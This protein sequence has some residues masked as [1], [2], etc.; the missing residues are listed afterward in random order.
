[1]SSRDIKPASESVK[2]KTEG[3]G[4]WN[5]NPDFKGGTNL[6]E[7]PQVDWA[8][9]WG[10]NWSAV[11]SFNPTDGSSG[12]HLFNANGAAFQIDSLNNI[13]FSAG[14]PSQGGCGGKLV[15]NVQSKITK[16]GSIATEVTGREDAGVLSK[17]ETEKGTIDNE[18]LPAYSLKVYGDILIECIGG[19]IAVKGDNVTVSAL[20][21]LNLKSEK[22]INIQAN[23]NVNIDGAN[24]DMEAASFKKN[25][26]VGEFTTGGGESSTE[27]FKSGA[28]I[29]NTTPGS[30]EYT[31]SGDYTVG[32]KGLYKLGIDGNYEF[33]VKKDLAYV[34]EGNYSSIIKGKSKQE[35]QGGGKSTQQ[36]TLLMSIGASKSKKNPG[37]GITSNSGVGIDSKSGGFSVS[38]FGGSSS[39][40]IDKKAISLS[41]SKMGFLEMTDKSTDIGFGK[42]SKVSM[43]SEKLS[44]TNKTGIYLN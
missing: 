4:I 40:K 35:V 34:V 6:Y 15:E 41:K 42:I 43:G 28:T 37:F 10:Q 13:I 39:F 11:T 7:V 24:I 29:K 23:G 18:K 5:I 36:E 33:K 31:V 14:K 2:T 26:S 44:I 3:S 19:D 38:A 20:T 17:K 22:D 27:Q 32:V 25:L 16:A 9:Q 21:T 8:Q 12:F 30:V 1:M